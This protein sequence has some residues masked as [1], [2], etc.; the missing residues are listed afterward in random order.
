MCRSV[1]DNCT[2]V[3]IKRF[4]LVYQGVLFI[5]FNKPNQNLTRFLKQV[6]TLV[7]LT[8]VSVGE[9]Q[10]LTAKRFIVAINTIFCHG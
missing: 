1:F 7:S 3:F 8:G 6:K 10:H 5:F 2:L 9:K 4:T